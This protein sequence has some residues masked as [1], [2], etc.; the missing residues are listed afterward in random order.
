MNTNRVYNL[1]EL[2]ELA[3]EHQMNMLDKKLMGG[4]FTQE[5]YEAEVDAI[6][7]WAQQQYDN[8]KK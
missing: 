8:L 2:I 3:V 4:T 1:E 7:V 6:I 5:E